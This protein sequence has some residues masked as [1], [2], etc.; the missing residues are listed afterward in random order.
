MSNLTLICDHCG[1]K[2]TRPQCWYAKN[3]ER[4]VK[5]LFCSVAC[6]QAARHRPTVKCINCGQ[7]TKNDRFCS[8]SCSSSYT[9]KEKPKKERTNSC[10]ACDALIP[11]RRKFCDECREQRHIQIGK[12]TLADVVTASG[13]RN[14]YKAIV[15]EHARNTAKKLGKLKQCAVC[16]Y[17]THVECCHIQPITKFPINTPII[18]VNDPNNLIGLCRNHHW[19]LDHGLLENLK[20]ATQ[21]TSTNAEEMPNIVLNHCVDCGTIITKHSV[22]CRKCKSNTRAKISWPPIDELLTMIRNSSF[23]AVSHQLGVSD[24]AIRKHIRHYSCVPDRI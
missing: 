1:N 7:D 21:K 22:R 11:L 17:S 8:R 9:N 3:L 6:F 23:L 12:A 14:S 20:T 13:S 15:G 18:K 10:T 2:F 19:E 4:G 16:N 24:N 5:R